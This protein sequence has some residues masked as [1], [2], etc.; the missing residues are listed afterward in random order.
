LR[1]LPLAQVGDLLVI[2]NTGAYGSS[3]SSNYNS[4]PLI[5]EVLVDGDTVT[6]GTH[7]TTST[8]RVELRLSNTDFVRKTVTTVAFAG[9]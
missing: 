2:E 5:A 7:A 6:T 3:M 8:I 4:R 1:E 9:T